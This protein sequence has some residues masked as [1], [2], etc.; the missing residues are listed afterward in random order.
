MYT[1]KT[2]YCRQ[3]S[4]YPWS[5]FE[6]VQPGP[7][8]ATIL[9][10]SH[11][12]ELLLLSQSARYTLCRTSERSKHF[13]VGICVKRCRSCENEKKRGLKCLMKEDWLKT[14][15]P[16]W[17]NTNDWNQGL[18]LKNKGMVHAQTYLKISPLC[19]LVQV[20]VCYYDSRSISTPCQALVILHE[21]VSFIDSKELKQPHAHKKWELLLWKPAA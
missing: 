15:I 18:H 1:G 2:C 3:V 16:T 21:L 17:L 8:T 6:A 20:A 4:L 11:F 12:W 13:P 10:I 14:V 5:T 19:M 9:F 7:Q